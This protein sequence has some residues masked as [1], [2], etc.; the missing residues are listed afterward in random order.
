MYFEEGGVPKSTPPERGRYIMVKAKKMYEYYGKPTFDVSMYIMPEGKRIFTAY[1]TL[2]EAKEWGS[3]FAAGLNPL[4]EVV[5]EVQKYNN[6][7]V[8]NWR[9]RDEILKKMVAA[10]YRCIDVYNDDIIEGNVHFKYIYYDGPD[11]HIHNYVCI[12][13]GEKAIVHSKGHGSPDSIGC[14]P[15][16][17]ETIEYENNE[18]E[19]TWR[20]INAKNDLECPPRP[21]KT[22][23]SDVRDLYPL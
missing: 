10:G 8:F 7:V 3:A 22:R 16:W 6:M 11:V 9:E 13:P 20:K 21:E 2:D 14:I 5:Q 15:H 23:I 17:D 12:R 4:P 19:I 18:G 1:S